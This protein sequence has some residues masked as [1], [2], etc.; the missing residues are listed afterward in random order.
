MLKRIVRLTLKSEKITEF[1]ENFPE[2]KK[3]ILTMPGC[4]SVDLY[5]DKVDGRVFFTISEWDDEVALNTYRH[6]DF[7]KAT[8]S[9]I[10]QGFDDKPQAWSLD[11]V[12]GL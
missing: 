12:N 7:F 6:S 8:W 9:Y 11:L 3:K 5:R 4:H 10:K 2:R 1:V